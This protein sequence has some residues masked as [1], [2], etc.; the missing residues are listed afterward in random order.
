MFSSFSLGAMC[1]CFFCDGVAEISFCPSPSQMSLP[2]FWC[3]M[4]SFLRR[5]DIPKSSTTAQ[6]KFVVCTLVPFRPC[7]SVHAHGPPWL[8]LRGAWRLTVLF[9]SGVSLTLTGLSTLLP[10]VRAWS[11]S[12]TPDET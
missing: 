7:V 1:T 2:F 8:V 11:L 6:V 5:V 10:R 12:E 9:L 3:L 4:A